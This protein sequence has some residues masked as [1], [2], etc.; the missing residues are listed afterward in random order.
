MWHPNEGDGEVATGGTNHEVTVCWGSLPTGS[1]IDAATVIDAADEFAA[2]G[3]RPTNVT[4][5]DY[6]EAMQATPIEE[7]I[8]PAQ[9]HALL[10]EPDPDQ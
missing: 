5:M 3:T 4:W 6:H 9:L 8:T 7:T 10:N 2:T 1:E